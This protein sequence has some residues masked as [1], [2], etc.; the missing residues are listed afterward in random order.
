[1]Q[2]IIEITPSLLNEL[3]SATLTEVARRHGWKRLSLSAAYHRYKKRQAT[4]SF[5]PS[6][7]VPV[8][9]MPIEQ[10]P[11]SLPHSKA[12]RVLIIGDTHVPFEHPKYL[13]FVR[14]TY[15]EFNCDTVVH[16]GDVV[17][18]HAISYH[19]H[20]PD[21][22][23]PGDEFKRA[24]QHLQRWYK[25][26]P[27]VMVC[28]GNHDE[29]IYRKAVSHGLPAVA[30]KT[31]KQI[32]NAPNGWNWNLSWEVNRVRYQH[33]TGTTGKLA[34]LNKATLNRQSSVIGHVH[35]YGGVAYTASDKDLIF[36]LNAGC[37]IHLK[38]YA[39]LYGRDFSVRPTLGCGVV[40]DGKQ[41]FFVPMDLG[42]KILFRGD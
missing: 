12:S 10:P 38:S 42:A 41:A 27:S 32:L 28:M 7:P 24:V 26:F 16:I 37:G 3:A 6:V 36:G 30:F 20:N 40:L 17:D 39:M 5:P 31:L 4:F 8:N 14:Q 13:D 33:G 2:K 25:A 29:L 11:T 9:G 35:S 19:D 15:D 34:H 1:M 22:L 18:C 23:S 21:G